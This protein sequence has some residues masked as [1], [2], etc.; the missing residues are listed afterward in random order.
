MK[1]TCKILISIMIC[2]VMTFSLFPISAN[3]ASYSSFCGKYPIPKRTL[4]Y[5]SQMLSGNDV[6]WFQCAINHLVVNE[7]LNT[8]KLNVDGVFGPSCLRATKDFQRKNKLTEDGIFGSGSR[9]K[10][11]EELKHVKVTRSYLNKES[12]WIEAGNFSYTNLSRVQV[13][14]EIYAHTIATYSYNMF[15]DPNIS[16]KNMILNEIKKHG[17]DVAIGGESGAFGNEMIT[18]YFRIWEYVDLPQ[19]QVKVIRSR[20][21]YDRAIDVKNNNKT[22]GTPIRLWNCTKS[23]G[24]KFYIFRTGDGEWCT[25]F[26]EDSKTKHCNC[27]DVVGGQKKS[28]V[29]VQLY[30]YNGTYAQ[31]W[32][33]ISIK[34][35]SHGQ[36]YKIQNRL[37]Y[38]LDAQWGSSEKGTP[39]WVYE[40]NDT[41]SQ[42]WYIEYL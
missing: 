33:L 37:G 3:A 12:C 23:K 25:I 13:A 19:T 34:S 20:L 9:A 14:A 22:D 39:I 17:E 24:Q 28:G 41:D 30:E 27:L 11:L 40:S 16:I 26:K 42:L 8:P 21:N 15:K 4:Q 18:A 32:R 5:K 2:V 1:K 10:M 38:Y 36:Y 29:N 6:K 35:D 31:D 7:R